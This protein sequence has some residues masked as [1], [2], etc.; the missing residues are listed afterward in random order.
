MKSSVT[1]RANLLRILSVTLGGLLL[2]DCT[3][4]YPHTRIGSSIGQANIVPNRIP[5]HTTT[6]S[7]VLSSPRKK[8]GLI[9]FITHPLEGFHLFPPHK[10]PPPKALALKRIGTI[11][12]LSNDGS[13]VI[14]ELEPGVLVTS[15]SELLVTG[16]A[17]G[18]AHLKVSELQPPY[19][20][21]DI[22]DGNPTLN[23]TVQ[24]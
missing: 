13:Y 12:T 7:E 19:F 3:F 18:P 8:N 11:R 4:P 6:A 21:A 9:L 5:A 15:G 1:Y 20:I 16:A 14:V 17:G 23:Q 2:S 10:T 24:Q 22:I